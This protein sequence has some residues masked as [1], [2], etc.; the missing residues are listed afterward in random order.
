MSESSCSLIGSFSS[1]TAAMSHAKAFCASVLELSI[2]LAMRGWQGRDAIFLPSS[3]TLPS[4]L[5]AWSERSK[6]LALNMLLLEG[7]VSQGSDM[8]SLS[9]KAAMS[10]TIGVRSASS[11][12]GF[13][14]S[15]IRCSEV[16]D[17]SR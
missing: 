17:H 14:C 16:F 6:C 10:R 3:V 4:S 13:L 15:C 2:I 5:I 11:I 1:S 12:S 8:G 7:G 9:P